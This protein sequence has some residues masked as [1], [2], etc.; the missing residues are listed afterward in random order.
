MLASTPWD[1]QLPGAGEAALGCQTEP[2]RLWLCRAGPYPVLLTLKAHSTFPVQFSQE[3][4]SSEWPQG[5][6]GLLHQLCT[7]TSTDGEAR[8]RVDLKLFHVA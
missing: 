2:G 6:Q 5:C 3:P 4:G 1:V 7:D 8:D